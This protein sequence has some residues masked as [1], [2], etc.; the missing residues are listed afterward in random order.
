VSDVAPTL[1]LLGCCRNSEGTSTFVFCFGQNVVIERP[2]SQILLA[3][4][5]EG[6][7]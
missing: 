1:V 3:D 6:G 5:K 7:G 2:R 4:V